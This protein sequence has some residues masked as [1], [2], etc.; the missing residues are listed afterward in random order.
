Y[1]TS[2]LT[3]QMWMEELINGHPDR[4]HCELGVRLHVFNILLDELRVMNVQKTRDV[5]LE[6]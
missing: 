5:S 3:G 1:H 2:A 6:E 4:I